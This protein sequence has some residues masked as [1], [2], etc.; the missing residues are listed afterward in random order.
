MESARHVDWKATAHTGELQ[1][2]EF[3]HEQEQAVALFLDLDVPDTN[4]AWFERAVD[5]CAYLAWTLSRRGASLRFVTQ[6]AEL[7]CPDETDVYAILKYLALVSP[8]QGKTLPVPHDQ[9]VFQVVFSASPDRL[10]DAGWN[11]E[12]PN[13]RVLGPDDAAMADVRE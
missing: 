1:V 2:R 9:D 6:D 4:A 7:R 13:V 10:A 11:L 3:A 5:C 8:R 12:E